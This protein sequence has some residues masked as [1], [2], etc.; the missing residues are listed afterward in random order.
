[1]AYE[2]RAGAFWALLGPD[3]EHRHTEYDVEAMVAA[4]RETDYPMIDNQTELLLTDI[5]KPEFV[6]DFFERQ[7]LEQEAASS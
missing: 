6:A 4:M 2:G 3:V 7:A 1:M 5:P